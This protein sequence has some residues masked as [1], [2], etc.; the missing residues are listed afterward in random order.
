LENFRKTTTRIVGD[1]NKTAL[2]F[3]KMKESYSKAAEN[4]PLKL[5]NI[6]SSSE[7]NKLAVVK[8]LPVKEDEKTFNSTVGRKKEKKLYSSSF[9]LANNSKDN[10]SSIGNV[11]NNTRAEEIPST[12]VST[13][14][15]KNG[16]SA[17]SNSRIVNSGKVE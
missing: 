13:H 17:F 3:N 15:L 8:K 2:R 14:Y 16:A 1:N 5:V 6:G 4:L 7:L 12:N 10:N 9:V 11:L